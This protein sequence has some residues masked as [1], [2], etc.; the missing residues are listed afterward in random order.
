[1][2][3]LLEQ[4]TNDVRVSIAGTSGTVKVKPAPGATVADVL[5]DALEQLGVETA[6]FDR[7]SAVRNGEDADHDEKVEPG[8][9]VSAA[10][11]V[12]NG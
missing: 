11:N 9:R 5:Q 8:D 2:T 12:A 6:D 10:P 4:A 7:L 1:M 3:A